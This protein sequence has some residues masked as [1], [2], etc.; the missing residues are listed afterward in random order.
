MYLICFPTVAIASRKLRPVE[1]SSVAGASMAD[2]PLVARA[3]WEGSAQPS[4][5]SCRSSADLRSMRRAMNLPAQLC[6]G[7]G[8]YDS[9]LT[10]EGAC[11]GVDRGREDISN[12]K[13]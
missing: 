10:G 2:P 7:A 3:A 6:W 13:T 1:A 8:G 4:C 11:E 12:F 5:C 9:G